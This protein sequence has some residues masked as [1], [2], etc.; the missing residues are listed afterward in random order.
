MARLRTGPFVF[1]STVGPRGHRLGVI[2]REARMKA[3][4]VARLAEPKNGAAICDGAA[5]FSKAFRA[6][7]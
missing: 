5:R 6:V 1:G 2:R 4:E 7:C 3:T